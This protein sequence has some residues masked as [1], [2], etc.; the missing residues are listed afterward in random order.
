M[1]LIEIIKQ[2]KIVTIILFFSLLSMFRSFVVPLAGDEITYLKISD[3]ILLGK[4]YLD[5]HPSTFNPI[6]P[7]ILTFFRTDF[8]PELGFI[9]NKSFNI[10]LFGIGIRYLY[11]FL[12]K[13]NI[14]KKVIFAIVALTVATPICVST[15]PTLYPDAILFCCFWGFIYYTSQQATITN[16]RKILLLFL[17]LFLVRYLYAVLGLIL[18]IYY[19]SL[20]KEDKKNLHYLLLYSFLLLVPIVIWFKYVYH[21][22]SNNLSQLTYFNRFKEE[23]AL[24]YNIKAGLGIIQHHEVNRINGIPAFINLWVP[25]TGFRNFAG[26]ILLL[27]AFVAGYIFRKKSYGINL[28]FFATILIM[29]GL[30]VAGTGFTRYWMP[31]VPAYYLGYYFLFERLKIKNKYPI[32]GMYILSFI[33]LLN[34]MRLNYTVVSNHL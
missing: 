12:K 31:L 14:D 8:L 24:L 17:L 21:I 26:S 28:L 1:R 15:A 16:L 9:L 25:I 22:E 4:F 2:E 13:Q 33:Y 11:L 18:L 30:I 32:Y 23:N 20:I 19:Y 5:N 6:I 34:E 29:L 7:F 27:S 10:L 3:N